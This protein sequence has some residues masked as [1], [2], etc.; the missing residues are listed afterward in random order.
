VVIATEIQI[1]ADGNKPCWTS[2]ALKCSQWGSNEMDR[3]SQTDVVNIWWAPAM[4][5]LTKCVHNHHM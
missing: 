1:G 2:T 3:C 4:Q 5:E